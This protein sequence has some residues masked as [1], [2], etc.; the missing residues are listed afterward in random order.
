MDLDTA[1]ELVADGAVI[2]RPSWGPLDCIHHYVVNAPN[3]AEVVAWRTTRLLSAIDVA[4]EDW[5]VIGT[6]H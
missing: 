5:C 3:G 1:L 6:L 4:A 2:S